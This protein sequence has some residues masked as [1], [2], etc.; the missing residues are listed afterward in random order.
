MTERCAIALEA[1]TDQFSIAACC[2][3]RL[4]CWETSPARDASPRVFQH[5]ERLLA[6]V[7]GSFATLDFVAFGC[8]PGS[9]TGIRV[10][11]AAAQALAYARGIPVCRVSSF[12]VLASGAY[13]RFGPG[14]FGLS[15][16]AR[17]QRAYIGM[18][19]VD[20]AGSMT[21]GSADALVDPDSFELP[22]N[23]A[24]VAIG[25]GWQAYPQLLARHGSRVLRIDVSLKPSA[26]ELM[27]LARQDF[28]A[29]KTVSAAQALPE[30]L[31]QQPAGQT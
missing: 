13:R 25:E 26:R 17:R 31:G 1:A 18:Y 14:A 7:G 11:A 6:E 23:A 21:V 9:F 3:D 24:F 16:D 20:A 12:R 15:F 2:A 30:Y 27:G 4:V 19:Q 5:C 22:G 10:V 28:A 29:G 8:G